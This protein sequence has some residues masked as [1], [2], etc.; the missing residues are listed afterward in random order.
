MFASELNQMALREKQRTDSGFIP[1]QGYWQ[2]QP[3]MSQDEEL[4]AR[5]N[6]EKNMLEHQKDD[7]RKR[8]IQRI[9][10]DDQMH[11]VIKSKFEFILTLKDGIS[12][13]EE[14]IE[15]TKTRLN[16]HRLLST[17]ILFILI[18]KSS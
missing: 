16:K 2:R 13:L 17:L 18:A 9:N 3:G 10:N 12:N 7:Q 14:L 15:K 1:N 11:S 5:H 4:E 6:Y 8:E